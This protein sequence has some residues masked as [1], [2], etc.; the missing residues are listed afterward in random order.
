MKV[1]FLYPEHILRDSC[2]SWEAA[3]PAGTVLWKILVAL[4]LRPQYSL[5]PVTG[6]QLTGMLSVSS[7]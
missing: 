7:K 6:P 4:K 3:H 2:T 1:V 5:K